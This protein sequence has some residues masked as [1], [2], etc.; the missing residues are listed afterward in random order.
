MSGTRRRGSVVFNQRRVRV[1]STTRI[2]TAAGAVGRAVLAGYGDQGLVRP[3][4]ETRFLVLRYRIEGETPLDRER[5]QGRVFPENELE[6]AL[7][8][9]PGQEAVHS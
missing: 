8:E 9:A 1:R 7:L 6:L 2:R 5:L 3:G 4:G